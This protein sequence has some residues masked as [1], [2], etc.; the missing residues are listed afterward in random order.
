MATSILLRSARSA[1]RSTDLASGC[2][3]ATGATARMAKPFSQ[4]SGSVARLFSSKPLGDDLIVSDLG[5]SNSCEAATEGK[6]SLYRFSA[7]KYE[8]AGIIPSLMGGLH[9]VTNPTNIILGKRHML[10]RPEG[11][12][13]TQ[14]GEVC[15]IQDY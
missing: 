13:Q 2:L 8:G 9:L 10:S 15:T 1:L 7:Q 4:R 12:S 5:T 6:G 3:P 14:R 11:D